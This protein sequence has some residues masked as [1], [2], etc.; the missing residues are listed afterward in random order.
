MGIWRPVAFWSRKLKEA[1]TR[2]SATDIEWLAVVDAVSLTWRHFLED[3]PFV[4]RSDHKALERKLMKSAH[5]PPIS[6][7]QSRWIERLLPYSMT[8][9]HVAGA[10]NIVA[11]ALSRYPC[12]LN[13]VTVVH[14]LLA[15]LLGRIRLAA[16]L[17]P[18]Y[19]AQKGAVLRG[20]PSAYRIEDDL[21]IKDG[22][23]IVIPQ[24]DAVR[25]LLMSE[26]HD[27]V[28]SGHF[29]LE[30]T[31]EK[32]RRTWHWPGMVNDV[33]MFVRSC[34][35]C[36]RTKHDTSRPPGLLQPI[37][38][39]YPWQVV[40]MDFVGKFTPAE[41]TEHNMCLV[42]VDKFSK[43]VLLEAVP[44][45]ITASQMAEIFIRRLIA[46]F[47]VPATVISDRGPQFTSAVWR[48]TLEQLGS[49][50]AL[51]SSHHP[52]TDGQTERTIQT[53]LRLVRA[54]ASE[55]EETWERQLPLFQYA[56][57]DAYCEATQTSPFRALYG[58]DPMS[59][60]SLVGGPNRA[61]SDGTDPNEMAERLYDEMS[62]VQ[63][64]M[65]QHQQEVAN[66]MKER[67]DQGRRPLELQ[68]GDL[69]LLSTR[70]HHL[71][72]GSRKHQHR[73]V[74]PYV[75]A[76]K[77]QENAYELTGLPPGVPTTQN[78]RFLSKY[79]LTPPAFSSSPERAALGPAQVDGEW[80]WEVEA[81]EDFRVQRNGNKYLVKWVDT[82]QRQWLSIDHL[83][84]CREALL[85]YFAS[86]GEDPP[87][88]VQQM[89]DLVTEDQE[90]G[91]ELLETE[92]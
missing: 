3:I 18:T 68:P 58:K 53:L 80:E 79:E 89:R 64:F 62:G 26:A 92:G 66:R 49:R 84:N 87:Q 19:Q 7:R 36:Q 38:S 78:V 13:T 25:T 32:V 11:D 59:P 55:K 83:T 33:R 6:P 73:R 56:L 21:L 51:A 65:R 29:G 76:R 60:L 63:E 44:E 42:M 46:H 48:E 54:F 57:N 23:L 91:L 61:A 41:G 9:E 75:V 37:L 31:L 35:R 39:K 27:P 22:G 2:Y 77:I 52:Q 43:Y 17:D 5:D 15:G 85:E 50:V 30:K 81:I 16:E 28:Y 82:P 86:R 45:T 72:L 12:R 10:D 70:S 8:F 67:Y 88:E 69:V 20:E 71:L 24:D 90:A 34:P 40:T 47:G 4:V 14:S 1:E 74:G